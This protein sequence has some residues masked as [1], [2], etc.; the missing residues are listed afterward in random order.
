MA[1]LTLARAYQ[2]S[3]DS[4][5]NITLAVTG[6][7]LNA[8]GDVVAQVAQ[9]KVCIVIVLIGE[10]LRLKCGDSW[11]PTNTMIF[12]GNMTWLVH[13]VSFVLALQ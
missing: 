2:H 3:F 10:F 7:S 13:F 6:G 12:Q 11:A 9:L 1:A 5:P 4:H 8:L